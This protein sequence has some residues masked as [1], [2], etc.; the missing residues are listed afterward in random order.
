ML[1]GFAMQPGQAKRVG[2]ESFEPWSLFMALYPQ[3]SRNID[4]EGPGHLEVDFI[5]AISLDGAVV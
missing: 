5:T 1:L 3:P 4:P 2:S